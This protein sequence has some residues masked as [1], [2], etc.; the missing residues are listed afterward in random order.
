[1]PDRNLAHS[2]RTRLETNGDTITDLHLWRLGPGHTG[3]IVS[4]VSDHP[5]E[6]AAYKTKLADLEGLSHITVEANLCPNH[7]A[8]RIPA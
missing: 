1:M 4:L 7:G 3:L 2:V 6:P 8:E 5:Q